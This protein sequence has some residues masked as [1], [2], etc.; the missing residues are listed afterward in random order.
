ME[1]HRRANFSS[2]GSLSLQNSAY[3]THRMLNEGQAPTQRAEMRQTG[4][5]GSSSHRNTGFNRA[6]QMSLGIPSSSAPLNNNRSY[7]S[8]KN[9]KT[10]RP[11]RKDDDS[12]DEES[13]GGDMMFQMMAMAQMMKGDT[14]E[15]D[16]KI[17]LI[18]ELQQ[19]NAQI[20][21]LKQTFARNGSP[22]A[23]QMQDK[24]DYLER[25]MI[26]SDKKSKQQ[27]SGYFFNQMLMMMMMNPSSLSSEQTS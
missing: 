21:A 13:S 11:R 14:E 4:M 15:D 8:G 26:E 19:Q 3:D 22:F 23:N 7:A 9:S 10:S 18:K 12:S 27:N 20:L 1:S 5:S 24:I 16:E 2:I 17:K 25:L 6:A